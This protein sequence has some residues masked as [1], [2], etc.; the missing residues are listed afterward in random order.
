MYSVQKIAMQ[1]WD[2]PEKPDEVIY[3]VNR[4]EDEESALNL[5]RMYNHELAGDM[6]KFRYI[7]VQEVLDELS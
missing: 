3:T 2:G 1:Y 6:W 5:A 7:V 4:C